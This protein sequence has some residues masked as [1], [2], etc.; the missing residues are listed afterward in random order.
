V[1]RGGV[2]EDPLSAGELRDGGSD[3]ARNGARRVHGGEHGGLFSNSSSSVG[4]DLDLIV[5]VFKT[6]G[7]RFEEV[8]VRDV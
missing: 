7:G 2:V 4:L 6:T 8:A 1:W 5:V 3:R